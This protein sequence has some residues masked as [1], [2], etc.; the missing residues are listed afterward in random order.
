M[1]GAAAEHGT[2]RIDPGVVIVRLEWG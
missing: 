2:A 1:Q